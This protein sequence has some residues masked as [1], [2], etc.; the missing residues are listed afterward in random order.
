MPAVPPI[1]VPH[2]KPSAVLRVLGLGKSDVCEPRASLA[3]RYL[4]RDTVL[5]YRSILTPCPRIAQMV[6]QQRKEA[7]WTSLPD[8]LAAI[9]V[10]LAF[11]DTDRTP[12]QWL[13]WALIC[14]H[15]HRS[16]ASLPRCTRH[17]LPTFA[18][19]RS[20]KAPSTRGP[21]AAIVLTWQQM[22]CAAEDA[23][24]QQKGVKITQVDMQ[25]AYAMCRLRAASVSQTAACARRCWPGR[26]M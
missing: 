7:G 4:P 14:R 23:Q 26:P 22:P 11:D 3:V 15:V 19:N 16:R 6:S 21:A 12:S 17:A 18:A 1:D 10:Q 25:R 13:R 2:R 24:H 5:V 8:H 9:I 20:C